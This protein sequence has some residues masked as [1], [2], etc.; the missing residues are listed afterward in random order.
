MK[1]TLAFLLCSYVAEQ[2]LPPY[3]WE[4]KFDSE[5]DCLIKWYEQSLLK[6]QEIGP[7]DINTHRIY[8]KF[9]CYEDEQNITD[10]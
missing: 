9:G 8:I 1:I 6:I 5:Y 2:C 4:T 3:I 7:D 10:L